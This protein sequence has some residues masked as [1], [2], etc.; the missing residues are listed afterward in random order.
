MTAALESLNI[1]IGGLAIEVTASDA[2][3]IEMLSGQ[4]GEFVD[5]DT[6]AAIRLDV[7]LTDEP[8][9]DA[10]AD[11]QVSREAG[12]WKLSRGDFDARYDP[13]RRYGTVRQSAN[14]HSIDSVIRIIH[15]LTLAQEGGFLL[16]SAS[17]I[18][19]E[20]AFLFAGRSGVGKTTLSRHAPGDAY[21]LSDE[22]SY[23]RK[24][25]GVFLAWGTPFTGELGTPGVNCSAPVEALCFLRQASE[26]RMV[27]VEEPEALRLLLGNV[28][29]FA[30]DPEL[31]RQVFESAGEF[32]AAVKT[33]YL[34]CTPGDGVWE[35]IR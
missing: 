19:N 20:H 3:F 5:V 30:N 17:A 6:C 23:V 13:V 25:G 27:T 24:S 35:L 21:L 22:V 29:F 34:D 32:V 14:R 31:V 18:R 10:D 9:A 1:V 11:V 26:N 33:F 4:Y 15:T 8:L 12:I 16:H 2:T 7:D 28:L